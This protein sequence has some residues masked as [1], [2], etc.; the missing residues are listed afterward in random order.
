MEHVTSFVAKLR[1]A[2]LP[3]LPDEAQCCCGLL[4]GSGIVFELEGSSRLN[5]LSGS[6]CLFKFAAGLCT[7]LVDFFCGTRQELLICFAL[8]GHSQVAVS[9]IDAAVSVCLG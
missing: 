7:A 4:D 9:P 5:T 6:F 3:G 8:E 1:R 2:A